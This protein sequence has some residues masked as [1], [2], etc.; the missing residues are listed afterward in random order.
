MVWAFSIDLSHVSRCNDV[1]P[2]ELATTKWLLFRCSV[3]Y[4]FF[5]LLV[6][7]SCC[8][9]YHS[10]ESHYFMLR[11]FFFSCQRGDEEELALKSESFLG[12]GPCIKMC[13]FIT[14][15]SRSIDGWFCE[16]QKYLRVSFLLVQT[17]DELASNHCGGCGGFVGQDA[18]QYGESLCQL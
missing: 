12:L 5:T 7:A 2:A 11:P 16:F 15:F 10:Y 18:A 8:R 13:S 4:V 1:L 6:Y 14:K 17:V 3:P 9:Y